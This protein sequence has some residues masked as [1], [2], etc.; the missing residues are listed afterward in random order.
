MWVGDDN[1]AALAEAGA[2]R[3]RA[4]AERQKGKEAAE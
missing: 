2:A 4:Q 3:R 1:R